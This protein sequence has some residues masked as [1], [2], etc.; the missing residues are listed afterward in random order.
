M[1]TSKKIILGISGDIGAGKN[2]MTDYIKK[3]W[4]GKAYRSSE[5]L[6]D[7]LKRLNLPETRENMQKISTS[8]RKDFGEDIISRVSSYD[9]RNIKNKIIAINGI[10]R[11][12]DL[13]FFEKDFLVKLVYVGAH[14]EK[15]FKR[16][17]QRKE[18][19]DDIQKTFNQFKKDHLKEAEKQTGDL[20]GKA[21]YVIKNNG[22]RQ[23]FY[24]KI[25]KI[26]NRLKK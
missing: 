3:K 4:R 6:R 10:R 9:L 23:E 22:T 5:I 25:D 12:S 21:D 1:R 14:L 11:M 20:R 7:I 16:I 17:S 8:L 18:N 13:K 26:I 15:R 24:K 19:S 2:E